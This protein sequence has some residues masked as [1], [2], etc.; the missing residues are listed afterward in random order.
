[1]E[2]IVNAISH[3]KSTHFD[4]LKQINNTIN[5]NVSKS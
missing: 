5:L 1:M 3:S 4:R 2:I